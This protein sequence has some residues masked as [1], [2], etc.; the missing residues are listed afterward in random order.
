MKEIIC[1]VLSLFLSLSSWVNAWPQQLPV[2]GS[3][4]KSLITPILPKISVSPTSVNFGNLNP[5]G[6][7]ESGVAIKNSG[8]ADLVISSIAISGNN[9]SD[10]SQTN[11]CTTI[12]A[13]SSCAVTITFGPT[14]GGKKSGTLTITSNDSKNPTI[15]VKLSGS[16]KS[17]VC[18]YSLSSSG[19]QCDASG[20]TWSFDVNTSNGCSWTATTRTSWITITSGSSGSGSGTVA[21]TVT[22]NTSPR[23]RTGK[24]TIAKQSFTVTQSGAGS[25]C[26]YSISTTNQNFDSIGG[27]GSVG[28]TAQSGCNWTVASNAGWI[29]ITSG[30]SGS[31]AGSVGYSV[32]ANTAT[33]QRTGTMTIAGQTFTVTQSGITCTYSISSASKSFDSTGG[34]GSVGVTAQNGCNWTAASNAGWIAVTSAASGSG[35]GTTTYTVESNASI[36]QRSGTLTIAGQT[37][38]VMQSGADSPSL[39]TLSEYQEALIES[40]GTPDYI[41]I[42]FNFNPQR[43]EETWIYRDLQKVYLF[44]DG[45]SLGQTSITV[46]PN[47]YSN[48]PYLDPSLFTKDTK[49]SDLVELL[50]TDYVPVDQSYFS[51]VIGDANF[52]TYHF[53]NEGL[54]VAFLDDKLITVQTIDILDNESALPAILSSLRKELSQRMLPVPGEQQEVVPFSVLFDGDRAIAA[55]VIVSCLIIK[56]F[57]P[58][59]VLDGTRSNCKNIFAPDQNSKGC[60]ESVVKE[61]NEARPFAQMIFCLF[62]NL[63]AGEEICGKENS[64]QQSVGFLPTGNLTPGAVDQ[65]PFCPGTQI[66]C[67]DYA[68]SQW[69]ACGPDGTQTRQV[70]GKIPSDC[71]IDP[72]YPSVTTQT[73]TPPCTDYTYSDW[74][75]CAS[76]G[77]QTRA[78]TG[79]VPPGCSGFPPNPPVTTRSCT[80]NPPCTGYTYSDWS[81][82]GSDG[83]QTRAVMGYKPDGC[84]GTPPNPPVT[85]QLCT[86]P[87]TSYTSSDSACQPGVPWM[88]IVGLGT[89][90]T[91]YTGVP[92]G[93]VG[94]ISIPPPTTKCCDG[95][96]PC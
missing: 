88:G 86:P 65:F 36:D 14:S 11:H 72:P 54:Y 78:V 2:S 28:V 44:W 87:C 8:K 68:Y 41:T 91:T 6:T 61:L 56:A 22:P 5:G 74:W 73:C 35:N 85:T 89:V 80:P 19:Q 1:T 31:G 60:P 40:Y 3:S 4:E 71:N 26:T 37:F 45:T 76:D 18:S 43:R 29:T 34:A 50:G 69:S 23:Q 81:A 7:S 95:F 90:T 59:L 58:D 46:D 62:Y 24:L 49:L 55:A 32:S 12:A 51:S 21:Y 20:G 92:A 63:F 33:S 84:S 13:G 57:Y 38:T 30:A 27:T 48:P 77:V 83:M 39:Y 70:T 16:A 75:T 67:T 15:N 66:K 25:S 82:C 42:G 94:G 96:N 79:Y 53:K 64:P 10:F 93:C 52:K 9:A 17:P 47:A